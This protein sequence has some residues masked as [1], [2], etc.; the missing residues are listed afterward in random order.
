MCDSIG[1]RIEHSKDSSI[2]SGT[3]VKTTLQETTSSSTSIVQSITPNVTQN[4]E[5]ANTN[6]CWGIITK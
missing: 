3:L 2:Y 6:I 1:Y 4:Y 5:E